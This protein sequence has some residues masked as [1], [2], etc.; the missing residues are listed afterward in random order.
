[1]IPMRSCVSMSERENEVGLF[2]GLMVHSMGHG[3]NKSGNSILRD[4]HLRMHC[5]IFNHIYFIVYYMAI[6]CPK[7]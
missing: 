4:S 5:I 7:R 2:G 3:R 6:Y 1:M